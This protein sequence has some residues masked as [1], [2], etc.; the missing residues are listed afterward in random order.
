MGQ[1]YSGHQSWVLHTNDV[2]TMYSL[3][4]N[5][6]ALNFSVYWTVPAFH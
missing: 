1:V 4:E 5:V 3:C 2:I 6:T